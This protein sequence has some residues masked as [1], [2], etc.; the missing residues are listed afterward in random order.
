MDII[1]RAGDVI[2]HDG[3]KPVLAPYDNCVLIMPTL[4]HVK[5]GLTVVRIGQLNS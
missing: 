4:V 3:G 5:P 1:A 2:A